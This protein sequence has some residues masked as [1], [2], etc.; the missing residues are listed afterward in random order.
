MSLIEPIKYLYFLFIFQTLSMEDE[1]Y[2]LANLWAA[3]DLRA[4]FNLR[5]WFYLV[6]S[7]SADVASDCTPYHPLRPGSLLLHLQ[8]SASSSLYLLKIA[9]LKIA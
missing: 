1:T 3:P 4:S 6:D 8:L 7:S 5:S 9:Y 2:W